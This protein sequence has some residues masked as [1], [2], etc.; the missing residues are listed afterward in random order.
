MRYT[1][2]YDNKLSPMQS[3][4][5][6]ARKAEQTYKD[7]IDDKLLSTLERMESPDYQSIPMPDDFHDTVLKRVLA[8]LDK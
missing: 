4:S 8:R 5:A 3:S 1:P 7:M 2:H 6:L